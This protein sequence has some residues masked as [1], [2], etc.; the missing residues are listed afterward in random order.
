MMPEAPVEVVVQIDGANVL[1]GRLWSHRRGRA[2]SATFA[3]DNSYLAFADAYE[4]DPALTLVAAQQQTPAGRGIFG[5]F[6][7]CAPDRWGRRLITRAEE[8]RVK[9]EGGAERSFGEIDYLLGVRDDMRQGALRFRPPGSETYLADEASGVPHLIELPSLL[10]AADRLERD[11]ANEEELSLLLRGGSS[12]GGARP[13]AHVL[14]SNGRPA[15]AKFPSTADDHDVMRWEAVALGLARAAGIEVSDWVL[16]AVDGKPVLIVDR[17]DR[18]NGLRIGFVSAM[19]MLEASDGDS[20]S[21]LEIADVIERES[22]KAGEDLRELW[23]RM[24]FSVLISNTDDHL[25]NHGFLRRS[26]SGWSL[27]PAFDL[28]PDPSPGV[29]HLSTSIGFDD[30]TASVVS[31]IEVR[32]NFR[33]A[34]DACHR[35]LREVIDATKEWRRVAGQEGIGRPDME[36]M[37]SAFEHA[38]AVLAREIV[39]GSG[40]H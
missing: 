28:N 18:S 14:G 20:G 9:R 19:T 17:F 26:S 15:I 38:Q 39:S 35:V 16:Q 1:A 22:P 3:Y 4:L 31:L 37:A 12:L 30:T 24:A 13:K 10:S 25:R 7:D 32:E 6:S 5:A 29:K 8:R 2:E 33:L 27:A 40:P 23:R 21:Y 34:E 11:E 36:E